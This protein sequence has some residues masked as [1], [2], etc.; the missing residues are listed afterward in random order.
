VTALYL[1]VLASG[2]L[3]GVVY[4]LIALGLTIIFGVMRIVNF[5][6]GEMVVIGMYTGYGLWLATHL[7]PWTLAPFAALLLFVLGYVLQRGI[8]NAFID[9]PQHAQFILFIAF[10][11]IITGLHLVLFGP[12][13]RSI[14]SVD[15]MRSYTIG[16]L[17]LDV[18]RTQAA[19]GALALIV[20]LILF[21]QRSTL[22]RSIRAAA[23][24]LIGAEVIGIRIRRVYAVTA[25][26]GMACAGAAGAL[27]SPMFDAQPFLATDFTLI[28][29]IIVIVGGLGSLTGALLGGVLIGLAEAIA[30]VVIS[31]ALKTTF[32]Y[33]LLVLVLM[34][35]PNGLFGEQERT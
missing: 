31:P 3:I 29:F 32:S 27:I 22:G 12:D 1:N 26:I 20:A 15:S 4:A 17:R 33:A 25:G 11:L 34:L 35:R 10:A 23:D 6:H 7:P 16:P 21:L 24:N 18:V 5:A 9:R 28:A 19:L 2:A 8:V 14:Q 13:S 30:A